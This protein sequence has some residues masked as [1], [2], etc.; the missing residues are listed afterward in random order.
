MNDSSNKFYPYSEYVLFSLS[1]HY[2]TT[3]W[4]R[5]YLSLNNW[6]A[7]IRLEQAGKLSCDSVEPSIEDGFSVMGTSATR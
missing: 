6:N 1:N 5:K 7:M 2:M 4:L 3:D